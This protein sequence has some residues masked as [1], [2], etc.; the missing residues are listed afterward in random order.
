[1]G[2]L[3]SLG[4]TLTLPG[5]AG[6]VL[7]I[8]MSVDANVLI[9]ERIREELNAGKGLRL[10]V[11]DGYK[12]AYSAIIDANVT[13]LLTGIILYIFGT[14]PIQGFATTIVIGICTS[15]FSAI[16][17]TRLIFLWF[18]DR[19]KTITFATRLTQDA[20]K[21]VHIKFI[22]KRKIFY[23]ISGVIIVIAIASLFTRGLSQ[24]I[25]FTGGRTYI[26]RF[27]ENVNT[28]DIQGSLFNVFGEGTAVIT[29]GGENQVRVST[30]FRIDEVDPKLTRK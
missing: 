25:D 19:N 3:A 9:F 27:D 7:T 11:S 1:M 30:N 2:V 17:I 28:S 20:F 26:V 24:G 8:G 23:V 12:N 29:F 10:A 14:G 22:E 5:I 15:L 4:A 18:L 21:N 16:F 13:T 6:I